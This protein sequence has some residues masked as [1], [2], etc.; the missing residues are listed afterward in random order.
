MIWLVASATNQIIC[1]PGNRE[2][3][4]RDLIP[5]YA[6]ELITKAQLQNSRFRGND[7]II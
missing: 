3:V 2:A 4:I 1:H 5:A 7:N 6:G